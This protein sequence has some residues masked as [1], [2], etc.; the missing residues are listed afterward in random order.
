MSY[1]GPFSIEYIPSQRQGK[2]RIETEVR[3][4]LRSAYLFENIRYPQSEGQGHFHVAW[5]VWRGPSRAQSPIDDF[6]YLNK[7][8]LVVRVGSKQTPA[9]KSC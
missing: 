6:T 1:I 7:E 9:I 4:Q 8:C 3:V 5:P 2:R